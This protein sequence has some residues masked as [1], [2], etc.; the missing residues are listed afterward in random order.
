MKKTDIK[1]ALSLCCKVSLIGW[2]KSV[3]PS[4]LLGFY[5]GL[6]ATLPVGP[7]QILCIRSFLIWGDISGTAALIGSMTGQLLVFS[8][9]FF[10]PMYLLILR[11]HLITIVVLPYMFFYWLRSKDLPDYQALRPIGSIRDSRVVSTFLNSLIFQLFNPILLPNATL[12]RLSHL[13][14][15]R[16]SNNPIFLIGSFLGWLIGHISLGQSS[17]LLMR[18]IEK[19][20]PILYLLLKRVIHRTFS[21]VLFINMLLFLGRAPVSFV[22][23]KF[24]N[25]LSKYD[26]TSLDSPSIAKW[27]C[28]PWPTSFFDP[29]RT[30]R[31]LRNK[32][33]SRTNRQ[34][35]PNQRL[36]KK[37]V[38]NYFFNKCVTDGKQRLV[39]AYL[40]SL[41]ILEKQLEKFLEN[42]D[43]DGLLSTPFLYQNWISD[44]V[45]KGKYLNNE[46][47]DRVR[48]LDAKCILSKAIEKKTGSKIRSNMRLP[49]LDDPLLSQLHRVR[50]PT[51]RSFLTIYEMIIS[52]SKLYKETS[53]KT[54][55]RNR[56]EI[57][58]LKKHKKFLNKKI[59][60]P[61]EALS[62]DAVE[63]FQFAFERLIPDRQQFGGSNLKNIV[64]RIRK[65]QIPFVTWEEIFQLLPTDRA[66]FFVYFEDMC[67]NSSHTFFFDAFTTSWKKVSFIPGHKQ[68]ICL[69]HRVEDLEKDLF[70]NIQF[71]YDFR[72]D[73]PGSESDIRNKRLRNLA[74]NFGKTGFR[75]AKLLKRYSKS[76]DFRRKHIKGSMRARRRKMLAWKMLQGKTH[77]PFFARLIEKP[78]SSYDKGSMDSDPETLIID[79]REEMNPRIEQ[80]LLNPSPQRGIGRLKYERLNL[81]ARLD[82]GSIHTGR[83]LL[84]V[85]QSNFRRYVKLP[86]LILFKNI[87]RILCFQAPEWG[88][89]WIDS[90]RESHVICSYDGE[91]FSE[92]RFPGRWLKDGVQIKILFPFQ[93]KPWHSKRKKRRSGVQKREVIITSEPETS[94]NDGNTNQLEKEKIQF[95]Y[96]T[97]WGFQTDVPFGTIVKNPPFWNPVKK[98]MIRVFKKNLALRTK[99]AQFVFNRVLGSTQIGHQL[100]NGFSLF[101]K[102]RKSENDT[103]WNNVIKKQNIKY[104]GSKLKKNQDFVG[105][106]VIDKEVKKE[107]NSINQNIQSIS[108]KNKEVTYAVNESTFRSEVIGQSKDLPNER[109]KG[110]HQEM[111]QKFV[112]EINIHKRH[113][114][115]L[116]SSLKLEI[117]SIIIRQKQLKFYKWIAKSTSNFV[118]LVAK[119]AQTIR[120]IFAYFLIE[121]R[122]LGAQLVRAIGGIIQIHH[123]EGQQSLLYN[124][125]QHTILLNIGNNWSTKF[126]SQAYLC[127]KIWSA[128]SKN[129]IDLSVLLN[130]EGS[131]KEYES[132]VYIKNYN[133]NSDLLYVNNINNV[134]EGNYENDLET[135]H[136]SITTTR[137]SNSKSVDKDK[138]LNDQKNNTIEYFDH[139]AAQTSHNYLYIDKN[140]KKYGKDW[141]FFKPIETLS[142]TDLKNWLDCLDRCNLPIEVWSQLSPKKW[143][144]FFENSNNF[145]TINGNISEEENKDFFLEKVDNYS[146]YTEYSSLR[147]RIANLRKRHKC[148]SLLH[149]FIDFS[150]DANIQEFVT[151]YD[152]LKR[153]IRSRNRLKQVAKKTKKKIVR[154]ISYNS[155]IKWSLKFDL[156]SWIVPNFAARMYKNQTLFIPDKSVLIKTYNALYNYFSSEIKVSLSLNN[157]EKDLS[158]LRKQRFALRR[159]FR[160]RRRLK[161]RSKV[162]EQK[163]E[164]L[165]ELAS[166]LHVMGNYDTVPAFLE[167]MDLEPDLL[168][169]IFARSRR[170]ALSYLFLPAC[171][172][173][174]KVIDDQILMYRMVSTL[175]KFKKRFRKQF[176]KKGFSGFV[177]T[178]SNK[179]RKRKRNDTAFCNIE[180]L[181]LPRRRRQ[182]RFLQSLAISN[183]TELS[184]SLSCST[185]NLI[186]KPENKMNKKR[187][188]VTDNLENSIE[189]KRIKR[190]LWPSHR[191]EELACL[192]RFCF[193]TTNGSRFAMLRI[194]MYINT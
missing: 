190:F 154:P 191:L 52:V 167:N 88:E 68:K 7:S 83:G 12:A 49:R 4:L 91:E 141:G 103:N 164:K 166:I 193:N 152:L 173:R 34:R 127:D 90:C 132:N 97:A 144:S 170:K 129:N 67:R 169:V 37:R 24:E 114:T 65:S 188:G 9:I 8:S 163:S 64:E 179:E 134:Y 187:N 28:K 175:L 162:L 130:Y 79:T 149:S 180:D 150:R 57:R 32:T 27:L 106:N 117:Q 165:R 26:K 146:I 118:L 151:R 104:A 140:I 135:N 113:D 60:L 116:S 124:Y 89:D 145:E 172:R 77:S 122:A 71:I 101:F 75:S 11:P 14:M 39:F 84:L 120:K 81:A 20:S 31:P 21:I 53:K 2:V 22:T 44:Q 51:S 125:H 123:E 168:D 115:N 192:N 119:L 35:F 16:Y 95:S 121:F 183:E 178:L 161:F 25:E 185:I 5:Y 18:Y 182:L 62:L 87:G 56:I 36:V 58:F 10:S 33:K 184:R 109:V 61:W 105:Q 59:P 186:F 94:F 54:N 43:S 98:E 160:L 174:P 55:H 47:K 45:K 176:D 3:N 69:A 177:L 133:E 100:I 112:D 111:L 40:P 171:P 23:R 137:Y 74:I 107:S 96:L 142:T 102:V 38:S 194:K 93:L 181:L 6:L 153:E 147:D 157:F 143:N 15:F 70:R 50:V 46:L 78:A 131:N 92:N 42:Y 126:L 80:E 29:C 155:K 85:L 86:L 17:R 128:S 82:M 158:R 19:D 156:A 108:V 73:M 136:K 138:N 139:I 72:I 110:N 63:V 30:N 48:L 148:N 76:S 189:V 66:S 1:L 41:S 13:V 159:C 99:Q